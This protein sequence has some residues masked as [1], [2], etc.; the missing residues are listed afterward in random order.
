[1]PAV[2]SVRAAAY[3]GDATGS[4]SVAH[5]AAVA[6]SYVTGGRLLWYL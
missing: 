6:A 3:A 2:V 4:G 1:M 5:A